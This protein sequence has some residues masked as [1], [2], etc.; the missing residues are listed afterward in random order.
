MGPYRLMISPFS[1]TAV[2]VL[3]RQRRYATVL[4]RHQS[5]CNQSMNQ[6]G[7]LHCSVPTLKETQTTKTSG[8]RGYYSIL[9]SRTYSSSPSGGDDGSSSGGGFIEKVKRFLGLDEATRIRKQQEK[10]IQ[11]ALNDTLKIPGL[12]L[13]GQAWLAIV[14]MFASKILGISYFKI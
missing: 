9:P 2:G 7:V 14:K 6:Q 5:A 12:G 3:N 13:L 8:I 4:L 10:A 11:N 1:S